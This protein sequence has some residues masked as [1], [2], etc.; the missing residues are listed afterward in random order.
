M[1]L[2]ETAEKAINAYGGRSLWENAKCIEAEVSA[3]GLAFTLKRR[4]VF[5]HAKIIQ[6]IH[7]PF[8][9]LCPIGNNSDIIGVLDG[10]NVRLENKLGAVVSERN[11]AR[12]YFTPGRR[13]FYWDDMDM[14]YFANY[15]FWNYFT[16]P[17]LLMRDDIDWRELEPGRLEARFPEGIPTHCRVQHFRFDIQTGYLIQ[18]DYTA[19]IISRFAIAANV[20]LEH[21]EKDGTAYPSKRQITPRGPKGNP[22][23]HPVLIHIDVHDFRLIT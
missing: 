1:G 21:G 4:P 16:L 19:D 3:S 7:R 13:I 9:T 6:D 8:S 15:A 14:A 2:S 11:H 5:R 22:L 17:G 23:K 18:H 10:D 12:E 20:V